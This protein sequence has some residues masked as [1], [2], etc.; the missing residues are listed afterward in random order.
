MNKGEPRELVLPALRGIMGD[1]VYYSC[2]LDLDELSSRVQYAAEVHSNKGLSDM[3]QRWLDHGHSV[4]IADYL[5]TQP[6]RLFSFACCCHIWWPAE[7]ACIR[8]CTK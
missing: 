6:Q 3:I 2:L 1:W 7:L 8:R 4:V 5:K